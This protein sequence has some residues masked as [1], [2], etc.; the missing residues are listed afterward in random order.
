MRKTLAAVAVILGVS[1]AAGVLGAEGL[2]SLT[3]EPKKMPAVHV[4]IPAD[5]PVKP[6]VPYLIVKSGEAVPNVEPPMELHIAGVT[7]TEC[8]RMGGTYQDR[9]RICVDVDY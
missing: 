5:V 1:V 7:R 4:T 3:S 9:N 2:R 6:G 8:D